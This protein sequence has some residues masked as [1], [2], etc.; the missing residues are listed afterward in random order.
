MI[1][2]VLYGVV[3]I[4]SRTGWSLAFEVSNVAAAHQFVEQITGSIPTSGKQKS[5]SRQSYQNNQQQYRRQ[6][7]SY[8]QTSSALR[9]KSA[10]EILGVNEGATLE[11]ISEA[12]RK[13]ARMNHPDKVANMAPEFQEMAEQRM[14]EINA[15]YQELSSKLR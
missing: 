9:S 13:Q 12:Y 7:T 11:E 15:A 1:P 10:Y 4:E 14:K 6:R 3:N 8:G 2:I 5:E